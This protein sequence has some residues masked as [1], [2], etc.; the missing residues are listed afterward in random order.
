L[1]CI[2]EI[3]NIKLLLT[4]KEIILQIAIKTI[5]NSTGLDNII[6]ILFVFSIYPRITKESLLLLSVTKRAQA[7]HKAIKE[8][9]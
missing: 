9:Y 2:Y 1:R 7:I 8:I 4:S 5:N 3:L 6:P